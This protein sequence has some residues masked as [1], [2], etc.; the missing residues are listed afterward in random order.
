[1]ASTQN[2]AAWL[3]GVGKTLEVRPAD[4]PA[5][6]IGELLIEVK[7][8]AVQPAEYKIQE[9]LLPFPLKYPTVIGLSFSGI[10]VKVGPAVARF[11]VGDRVVTNSAGTIRNDSRFGAY[12]RY[13][14]TTQELTAKIGGLSFETASSISNL[15]GAASALFLHLQLEKPSGEPKSDRKAEKVLI[16]G[17]SSSFGAYATQLAAEAGYAVVGVASARNAELVQSF[18]AAHFVDRESPGTLQELVALGPFKAVLAAA[19]TAQDQG[20]IAAM[21]AAHGG[22]SFLS[23]MGLRPDVTLPPG[24]S[25]HFAQFI[26]DYLDPENREFTKWLWWQYLENTLESEKLK[27]LPVRVVGGLSQVQAAWDLLKQGKVSGQRLVIVPSLE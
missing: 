19:D 4:I 7:A 24:V 15:Y 17:A 3:P 26:D 9:G 2:T 10:V 21:L 14:L 6:G 5:P 11:K 12:Q 20:L 25:G 1:M 8:V 16:W 27:L 23:T 22:G 13:A 18:G